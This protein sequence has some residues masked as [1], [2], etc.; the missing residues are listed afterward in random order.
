MKG[1][2]DG[3]RMRSEDTK[4]TAADRDSQLKKLNAL[5]PD[6]VSRWFVL[7]ALIGYTWVFFGVEV[8]VGVLVVTALV[9]YRLRTT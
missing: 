7:A 2:N 8:F 1:G 4:A 6:R 9:G 3:M 5:T